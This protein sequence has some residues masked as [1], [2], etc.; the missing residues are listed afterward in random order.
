MRTFYHSTDSSLVAIGTVS[1]FTPKEATIDASNILITSSSYVVL[2]QSVTYQL[3]YTVDN[4]VDLGGWFVMF[5]PKP[6]IVNTGV[7]AS[8]CKRGIN[9]ATTTTTPCSLIS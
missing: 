8:N 1:G 5:V 3:M 9:T 2:D 4:V 6:I 7:L